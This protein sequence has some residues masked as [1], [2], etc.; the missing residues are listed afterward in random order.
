MTQ[1]VSQILSEVERLSVA[2]RVE[3][4]RAI[5]ERTPMSGD[6]TDEDFGALAA[7]SFRALDGEEAAQGA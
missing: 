5:V 4:R 6:L 1:A 2:E 3:L 7:E